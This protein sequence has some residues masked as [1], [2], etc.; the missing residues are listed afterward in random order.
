[1]GIIATHEREINIYYNSNS[2]FSEQALAILNATEYKIQTVDLSKDKVTPTQWVDI[3]NRIKTPIKELVNTKH[4]NFI[5]E[6][7]KDVTIESDEDWL[8]ILTRNPKILKGPILLQGERAIQI[9]ALG[10]LFVFLDK[11]N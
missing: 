7:G 11:E 10:D 5:Q 4:P 2:S 6:Y 3:A 8:K 9:K 1:M